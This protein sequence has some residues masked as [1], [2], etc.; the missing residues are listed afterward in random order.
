MCCNLNCEEV[1]VATEYK[2]QED[3]RKQKKTTEKGNII[4][5]LYLYSGIFLDDIKVRKPKQPSRSSSHGPTQCYN[6][7]Y[8]PLLFYGPEDKG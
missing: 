7:S 5:V 1:S 3:L 2:L 6:G 4:S 8:T